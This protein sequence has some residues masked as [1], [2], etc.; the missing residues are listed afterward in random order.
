MRL[1]TKWNFGEIRELAIRRLEKFE[2]E[3]IEKITTYKEYAVDK[4]LLL[5]SYA[6]LCRR[7]KRLSLEEADILGM[8]A[9]LKIGEAREQAILSASERG[10]RTPTTASLPDDVVHAAVAEIFGLTLHSNDPPVQLEGQTGNTSGNVPVVKEVITVKPPNVN[11]KGKMNGG[12][13][14]ESPQ[15]SPAPVVS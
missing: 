4:K 7:V 2:L 8:E 3:P 6:S 15:S 5:P 10:C 12:T 11:N 13:F 9:V 14:K 1:A